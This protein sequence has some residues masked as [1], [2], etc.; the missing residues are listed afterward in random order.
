MKDFLQ[1]ALAQIQESL[2]EGALVDS[3]IRFEMSTVVQHTECGGLDVRVINRGAG[4]S[5]N[6]TQKISLAIRIPDAG[7]VSGEPARRYMKIVEQN[8]LRPLECIPV[9]YT[10]I[11]KIEDPAL[12]R[13][14]ERLE[15]DQE[16]LKAT[17]A[18]GLQKVS[19]KMCDM[20]FEKDDPDEPVSDRQ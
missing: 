8:R 3:Q 17:L 18:A 16:E 9:D 7:G 12:V 1:S 11:E 13:F 15:M 14:R 4:I 5:D 10:S 2:P 20:I 6:E 19:G